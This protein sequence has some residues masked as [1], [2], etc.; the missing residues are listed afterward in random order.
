MDAIAGLDHHAR[1]VDG[2]FW[3]LE[4]SPYTLETLWDEP[5]STL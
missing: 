5:V 1:Y 4:G 2:S 3:C